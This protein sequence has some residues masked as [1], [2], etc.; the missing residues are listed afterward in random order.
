[1]LII[2]PITMR[3]AY[4]LTSAINNLSKVLKGQEKDAEKM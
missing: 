3:Q 1:M 2:V 4:L